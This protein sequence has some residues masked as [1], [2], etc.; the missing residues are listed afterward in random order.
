MSRILPRLRPQAGTGVAPQLDRSS[1]IFCM[2]KKRCELDGQ[3]AGGGLL[4]LRPNP[5][6]MRPLEEAWE[7]L[8]VRQ[9]PFQPASNAPSSGPQR[10]QELG[11]NC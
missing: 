2:V 8:G 6:V 11:W 3:A 10:G 5:H 1:R 7:S 9:L 4:L